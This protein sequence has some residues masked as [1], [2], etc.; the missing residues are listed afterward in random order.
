VI[1]SK[2]ASVVPVVQ[3]NGKTAPTNGQ[4]KTEAVQPN[5]PFVLNQYSI[6]LDKP[7]GLGVYA[8]QSVGECSI[9][10]SLFLAAPDIKVAMK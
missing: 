6:R 3:T 8:G 5:T 4:V 7:Y 9:K 10:M 2:N 1:D